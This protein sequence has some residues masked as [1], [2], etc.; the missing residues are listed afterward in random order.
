MSLQRTQ[1]QMKKNKNKKKAK[2]ILEK[3]LAFEFL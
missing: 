1:K 2:V 3:K